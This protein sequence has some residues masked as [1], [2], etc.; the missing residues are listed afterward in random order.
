MRNSQDISL[1]G[2][3]GMGALYSSYLL[4]HW[5]VEAATADLDHEVNLGMELTHSREA[6][7]KEYGFLLLWST[8]S[9]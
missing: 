6:N 4:S 1:R 5:K 2:T 3:R 8:I 7:R 9:V